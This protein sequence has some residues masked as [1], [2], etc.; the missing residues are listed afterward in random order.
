MANFKSKKFIAFLIAGGIAAVANFLSRFFYNQFTDYGT[1]IVLA[2]L[3]GMLTA[4]LL[5]KFFVFEP[6]VHKTS[7]QVY[8]F[9]LVNIF[10]L[11]QTFLISIGLAEYLF[12]YLGFDYHS[13]AIAHA[14]GV[15]FPVFTSFIGHQKFSFKPASNN[16]EN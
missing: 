11:A 12:P 4:F 1:A 13:K 10:A 15:A 9:T 7:K 5:N 3:T 2:Y 16:D 6:S 8:Y 14:I